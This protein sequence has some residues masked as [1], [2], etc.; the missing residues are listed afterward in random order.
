MDCVTETFLC[1]QH[2]GYRF[3]L[4]PVHDEGGQTLP[5]LQTQ[6]ILLDLHISKMPHTADHV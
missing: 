4:D 3:C 1:T 5:D 2:S 6:R